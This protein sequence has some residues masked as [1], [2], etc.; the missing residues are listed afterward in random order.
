MIYI[1]KVF[2]RTVFHVESQ[3]FKLSVTKAERNMWGLLSSGPQEGDEIFYPELDTPTTKSEYEDL[4]KRL[5]QTLLHVDTN[6]EGT[7][8]CRVNSRVGWSKVDVGQ[9][10]DIV[11]LFEKTDATKGISV[12]KTVGILP[13]SATVLLLSNITYLFQDLIS[14]CMRWLCTKASEMGP[15]TIRNE[16]CRTDY[17]SNRH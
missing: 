16:N 8:W 5:R 3:F 17:Q 12:V 13:V 1:C 10:D 9:E 6:P 11:Q 15:R 4:A 7:L 2:V 14:L